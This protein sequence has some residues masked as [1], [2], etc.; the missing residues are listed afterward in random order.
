MDWSIPGSSILWDIVE[1]HFDEAAFLWTRWEA[2]LSSHCLSLHRIAERTEARLM[3]HLDGLDIAGSSAIDRLYLPALADR[4]QSKA[5]VAAYLL[6]GLKGGRFMD[7]LEPLLSG[8]KQKPLMGVGR[9]LELHPSPNALPLLERLL[10]HDR[11]RIRAIGLEALSFRR[12]AGLAMVQ[13]HGSASDPSVKQAVLRAVA[14]GS[15]HGLQ[16]VATR[17]LDAEDP[18]LAEAALMAALILD[19]RHARAVCQRIIRARGSSCALALVALALIDGDAGQRA[20]EDA[21]ELNQ[22]SRDALWALGFTGTPRAA[23]IC[24]ELL[25]DSTSGALAFEAFVGIT[26]VDIEAE[27]LTRVAEIPGPAWEQM[28]PEP[29]VDAELALEPDK[30]LPIPEPDAV[31][32]WWESNRTRFVSNERYLEGRPASDLRLLELLET[33]SMRR[34]AVHAL[35][36][37]LRTEGRVQVETRAFSP[38]QIEDLRGAAMPVP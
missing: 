26:G 32:R 10:L 23:E 25:S 7:T 8:M 38:R 11:P 33:A 22:P 21:L 12:K 15:L 29:D 19:P 6:I 9:A 3:A 31:R 34:R 30:A 2:D 17:H 27:Q 1:E 4:D 36:L 35:E 28:E 18:A 5:F 16:D 20:A 14:R 13:P 37:S 24:L